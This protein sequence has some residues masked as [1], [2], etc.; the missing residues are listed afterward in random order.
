MI[1]PGLYNPATCYIVAGPGIVRIIASQTAIRACCQTLSIN[2]RV[3]NS[4]IITISHYKRS[5]FVS[6]LLVILFQQR[7]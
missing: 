3:I 2:W 5:L 4:I 7:T 1:L 6:I